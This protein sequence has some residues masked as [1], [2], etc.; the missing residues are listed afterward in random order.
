MPDRE[1]RFRTYLEWIT[2]GNPQQYVQ[3]VKNIQQAIQ[4]QTTA[5]ITSTET[6]VKHEEAHKKLLSTLE[7]AQKRL[8]EVTKA[9]LS[10]YEIASAKARVE[11]AKHAEE[12][13]NLTGKLRESDSA[14]RSASNATYMLGMGAYYANVPM[15]TFASTIGNTL[16]GLTMMGEGFKQLLSELPPVAL[17]LTGIAAVVIGIGFA[18]TSTINATRSMIFQLRD[19]AAIS[20]QTL[21]G[22]AGGMNLA[23]AAIG[24]GG[25]ATMNMALAQ[26]AAQIS[27]NPTQM[28]MQGAAGTVPLGT[29][30]KGM[31]MA[32]GGLAAFGI[33][34][35]GGNFMNP[36]VIALEHV[37]RQTMQ[38]LM[39]ADPM[40]RA[41]LFMTGAGQFGGMENMQ[42][43]FEQVQSLGGVNAAF[44]DFKKRGTFGFQPTGA[45]A[46]RQAR[47]SREFAT[48]GT[49]GQGF[50]GG[51]GN[52][53]S[54]PALGAL[55]G[56][57]AVLGGDT[58]TMATAGAGAFTAITSPSSFA[59]GTGAD[60]GR[61]LF[62]TLQSSGGANTIRRNISDFVS[63][64]MGQLKQAFSDFNPILQKFGDLMQ[65]MPLRLTTINDA[66]Q[67][68]VTPTTLFGQAWTTASGAIETAGGVI[69]GFY[70]NTLLPLINSV[71]NP[72]TI[73]IL[74]PTMTV[75]DILLTI[76][77][78]IANPSSAAVQLGITIGNIV[79]PSILTWLQGL[80][81]GAGQSADSSGPGSGSTSGPLNFLI[82]FSLAPIPTFMDWLTT[83]HVDGTSNVV[84]F[85]FN[86][87]LPSIPSLISWL[88]G[89]KTDGTINTT[90]FN[91]LLTLGPVA[92]LISWVAGLIADG[93][94]NFLLFQLKLDVPSISTIVSWVSGLSL[95]NIVNGILFGLS[96]VLNPLG[97]L[98]TWAYNVTSG[99]L[100]NFGI[101]LNVTIPD[102][103]GIIAW[104]MA[105]VGG[106]SIPVSTSSPPSSAGTGG[107]NDQPPGGWGPP[108]G[109][110]G[111]GSWSID[112]TSGTGWVWSIGYG[113]YASGGIAWSP[114]V[115]RLA[116]N[117]PEAII[118][119]S[120][121]NNGGGHTFNISINGMDFSDPS[122]MQQIASAVGNQIVTNLRVANGLGFK[123][124]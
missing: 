66:S 29:V 74:G 33:Q 36:Q 61:Q 64:G 99:L 20:G 73:T 47:L 93:A 9:G 104:L 92:A 22:A 77:G 91:L 39:N 105:N 13:F 56:A 26:S 12:H 27:M 122:S 101:S 5:T 123:P 53:M 60:I 14:L 113:G 78:W 95:N 69:S 48:L 121:M 35:V 19:L 112:P 110:G 97:T 116:E 81:A 68:G 55:T 2:V 114:Q 103:G 31:L 85:G 44:A 109:H 106:V 54:V 75:P 87:T 119:L 6:V 21:G 40:T 117:G 8:D 65:P 24:P 32:G 88:M 79:T 120:Q 10:P 67:F 16:N 98:E 72:I 51:L 84:F 25:A 83:I 3:D 82:G 59:A 18:M 46:E 90:Q 7:Q 49:R 63:G 17:A 42:A 50:I 37:Q 15:L 43:M 76:A 124:Y 41:Q 70:T 30:N 4:Q 62:G 52:L 1:A 115:A 96:L 111:E 58:G 89:V 57:N 108:P 34:Q 107:T 23:S 45:D 100:T 94:I 11:V 71:A 28:G 86:L 102:P 118:P 80:F 38:A